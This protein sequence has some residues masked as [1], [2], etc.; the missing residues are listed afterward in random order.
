[1]F[2]VERAGKVLPR[3]T[4]QD[5]R[6]ETLSDQNRIVFACSCEATM[7]LDAA[8]LRRGCGDGVRTAR[9]LC[10][11]ELDRFRTALA[12]GA[13]VTV[14]CTQEAPLFEDV[15]GQSDFTGGLAFANLRETAGWSDEAA[16]A[17][18]KMAAL[19]AAA[20]V[21]MPA[22][23]LVALESAGVV[24][25]LG[26][27]EVAIEAGRSLAEHLDVTVLLVPG[28]EATPLRRRDFPVLQG[29]VRT[30]RGHLG[31]FELT[32]DQFAH[33]APSSRTRLDFGTPQNGAM[34]R[35]DI[36][37]DITGA[38]PLF[39]AHD[40]RSGYLRADPGDPAS[41][42]RAVYAAS[43]LVGAFDK[44]RFVDYDAGLCAHSRSGITGCT[45]CL[46]L[47]PTGA[48]TPAGDT[49][50]IDPLICAGCGQ[51]AAA[52]PTGAAS[53]ALP[54]PEAMLRRLRALLRTYAVA[55]GRQAVVLL[56]DD[57]QGAEL[58]E[59]CGRFGGGLP[60]RVLPLAVNE[61]GQIGPEILLAALAYGAASVSVL[62]RRR[63]RHDLR[64][65]HDALALSFAIADGLG[66]GGHAVG[67]IECDDPDALA[68][69][70]ARLSPGPERGEASSFLPIGGKRGLTELA[71]REL[72]RVAPAP[73]EVVALPVGSPFGAVVLDNEVCSLCLAC[74]AACPTG[75]LA[76][77]AEQPMLRFTESLCVQCG[78]CAATC[79]EEAI[80]LSPQV[81]FTAWGAPAHV[82][83]Q[84]E[85]FPCV[86][87]GKP[88]GTRSSIERVQAKLSQ[89]WM[90]S[91]AESSARRGLLLMCE[92]CRV[93]TVV[94]GG[95]DPHD[96]D[97]PRVRTTADYL[98][99]RVGGGA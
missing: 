60:A 3:A 37:L 52:C 16:A 39:P 79:P 62:G 20:A 89:H 48:I 74:V 92:D 25:I 80:T 95:F 41:V 59:A 94:A 44:P 53:Y 9:Q 23:G 15:A 1:M 55:G 31:G 83:K 45:R 96:P 78:L 54:G 73:V 8:A 38:P 5:E 34:S 58:I 56:H 84:E 35:A 7:P 88:F 27:N 18:P 40:L 91:G 82:L 85:P 87:C 4:H 50:A 76:D 28:V 70:L 12:E 90:F 33:P 63:P 71:L 64:G 26:R 46:A 61:I 51:C 32:V 11:A 99:E 65:L 69:A 43:H 42:A 66:Y 19:L 22:I 24:L 17:G 6:D 81:D 75:A 72:R 57:A 49:V 2:P 86:A 14:G 29:R 47:C 68:A 67:M 10:R 30:A 21:K 93:R 36:L 13:P 98:S 97:A 77:N